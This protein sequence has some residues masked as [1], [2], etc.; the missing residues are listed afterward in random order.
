MRIVLILWRHNARKEIV[1]YGMR[2]ILY[3]KQSIPNDMD[4]DNNIFSEKNLFKLGWRWKFCFKNIAT[5]QMSA[6]I[7]TDRFLHRQ[8]SQPKD[9]YTDRRLHRQIY[10]PTDI[11]TGRRFLHRQISQPKNV[12]TDRRF[13]HRQTS[14]PTEDVYTDRR[15]LHRQTS[16]PT[17]ISTDRRLHR[18]I[19][20]PT[21]DF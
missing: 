5:R 12:Y 20:Q 8:I 19:S 2:D 10:Q 6:D 18:Q 16:P 1:L 21:E 9:V 15:F 13:L 7:S 14:P 4:I 3:N 17:D 11:S